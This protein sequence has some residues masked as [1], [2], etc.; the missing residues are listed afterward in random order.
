[1]AALTHQSATSHVRTLQGY[2][3]ASLITN[4]DLGL[5]QA[6]SGPQKVKREAVWAEVRE[7]ITRLASSFIRLTMSFA[8][9]R[10]LY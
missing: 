6:V 1:M 4:D 3:R 8:D 5:L 7:M 10:D 2:Q 9:S